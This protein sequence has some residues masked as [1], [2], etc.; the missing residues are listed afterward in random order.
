[1]L[2]PVGG[3][4]GTTRMQAP[5]LAFDTLHFM[6]RG[7]VKQ[8]HNLGVLLLLGNYVKRCFIMPRR[9]QQCVCVSGVAVGDNDNDIPLRCDANL[10]RSW[11]TTPAHLRLTSAIM[12]HRAPAR[13]R[14]R[15]TAMTSS[16]KVRP[17]SIWTILSHSCDWITDADGYSCTAVVVRYARLCS[18]MDDT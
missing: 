5:A 4:G 15:S 3:G 9:R 2:L 12:F 11:C 10:T 18:V 1:M 7:F 17:I 16:V 8:A 13:V 14:S 6:C